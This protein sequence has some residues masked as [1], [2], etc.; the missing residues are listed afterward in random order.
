VNLL[1]QVARHA[2]MEQYFLSVPMINPFFLNSLSRENIC[3]RAA[4][5]YSLPDGKKSILQ[6]MLTPYMLTA[7]KSR[8]F[9]KTP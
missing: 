1:L 8:A 7:V 4:F 2:Q 9:D 6:G 5:E 3:L